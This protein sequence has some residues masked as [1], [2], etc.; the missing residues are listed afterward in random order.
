MSLYC[1]IYLQEVLNDIQRNSVYPD[2]ITWGVLALGCQSHDDALALLE[3]MDATGHTLNTVIAGALIGNAC[4][5]NQYKYIVD[6]MRIMKEEKVT[7]S[8]HLYQI[9][10]KFI[11]KVENNLIDKVN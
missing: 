8:Q 10:D 3:G 5:T 7:P 9:I 2:V 6:I 1:C 4:S 11:A